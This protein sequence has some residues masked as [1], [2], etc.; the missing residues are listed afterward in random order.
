MLVERTRRKLWLEG[1]LFLRGIHQRHRKRALIEPPLCKRSKNVLLIPAAALALSIYVFTIAG[2]GRFAAFTFSPNTR[3]QRMASNAGAYLLP[4]LPLELWQIVLQ[5]FAPHEEYQ[6]ALVCRDWYDLARRRREQRGA[7]T[8]QTWIGCYCNSLPRLEWMLRQG[9]RPAP[10]LLTA[11]VTRGNLDVVECVHQLEDTTIA[12]YNCHGGD[13]FVCATAA[14]YGHLHVLKYLIA[15]GFNWDSRTTACAAR[16][17]HLE[18][19]K[20]A[21]RNHR[22][23]D[24]VTS[25]CA[26]ES[27]SVDALEF[28]I[29]HG[30]PWDNR[31]SISAAALGHLHILQHL[32]RRSPSHVTGAEVANAAARK[33]HL[34]IIKY[35]R[36]I[37]GGWNHRSCC[38]AAKGGH[39]HVVRYLVE[40]GCMRDMSPGYGAACGGHLEVL[41]YLC[42]KGCGV[43]ASTFSNAAQKSHLPLL[44][45]LLSRGCP[46]ETATGITA[47]QNQHWEALH[48]LVA[49]GCPLSTVTGAAICQHGNLVA[50]KHACAHGLPLGVWALKSA[51]SFGH[52]HIIA[53]VLKQGVAPTTD[54]IDNAATGGHLTTVAFLHTH[55]CP[56]HARTTYLAASRGN[57]NV[58][59][60]LTD[61][62]CP[63]DVYESMEACGKNIAT[64]AILAPIS[65]RSFARYN[66]SAYLWWVATRQISVT[67]L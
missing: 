16:G 57:F 1:Q 37:G 4:R 39:L 25:Q 33:G 49:N 15:Q 56:W 44:Q 19:L 45:F 58:L 40:N 48:F 22:G 42:A 46:M 60:Y 26:A 51:A 65:P 66:F 35:I 12:F 67:L 47:A 10:S 61:N 29:S 34:H 9:V 6:F 52:T 36:E 5:H 63:C 59:Q 2:V 23:I 21:I 31:A 27:G 3:A 13:V 62:G 14:A 8:W 43:N 30:C 50:L 7:Q 24:V 64:L 18:V 32:Y 28:A 54:V 55:G 38:E 20:F 17:A 41:E 11:A 53:W